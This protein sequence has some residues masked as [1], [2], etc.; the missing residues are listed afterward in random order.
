MPVVLPWSCTLWALTE[1]AAAKAQQKASNNRHVQQ[2][3]VGSAKPDVTMHAGMHC[4]AKWLR[5]QWHLNINALI[6]EQRCN[7]RRSRIDP[8]PVM[9]NAEDTQLAG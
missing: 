6:K 7:Y 8:D 1:A 5:L 2:H 9:E 3:K 4:Y